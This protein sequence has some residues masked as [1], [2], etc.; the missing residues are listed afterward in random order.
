MADD[1][2]TTTKKVRGMLT[3]PNKIRRHDPGNPDICPVFKLHNIVN[4]ARVPVIREECMSG[5]LGCVDCKSE[6]A[7]RLN[8]AMQPI[9]ERRASIDPASVD[10][11]LKTGA[12]RAREVARP[13]LADVKS[14][15]RM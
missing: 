1:A 8:E 14:A 12:E 4:P 9:R 11:I 13:T 2:A 5:A 10:R 6:C 15:M 3:D 7:E